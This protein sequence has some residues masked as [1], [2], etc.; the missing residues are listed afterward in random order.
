M[1]SLKDKYILLAGATGG[2]GRELARLLTGSGA[3]LF[4]TGR[5]E[6]LLREIATECR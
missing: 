5:K 6:E 1:E 3:R 2:I 4:I